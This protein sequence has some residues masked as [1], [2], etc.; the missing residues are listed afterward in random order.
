MFQN[1]YVM[2]MIEQ[3][4]QA[5]AALLGLK[6]KKNPSEALELNGKLFKRLFGLNPNLVR[7]LSERDLIDLLSWEGEAPQEKLL[8][9]AT[10]LKEEGELNGML[11]KPD[12]MYRFSLKALNLTLIAASARIES[13][14][15]DVGKQIDELT[16]ALKDCEL[17]RDT[18]EMLWV[19]YGDAGRFADAE[20]ILFELLELEPAEENVGHPANDSYS[21]ADLDNSTVADNR[22]KLLAEAES[23]YER[24]LGLRDDVLEAGRLPRDEVKDSLASIRTFATQMANRTNSSL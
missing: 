5:I 23:F 16:E 1:D 3:F 9:M 12:A 4:S 18:K 7:V 21:N 19:Y 13:E 15:L 22:S 11:E 17:P 10:L 6:Q 24:L 20:D 8:M 14:W 2:R